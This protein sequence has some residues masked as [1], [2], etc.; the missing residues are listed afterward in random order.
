M[1]RLAAEMH[2]RAVKVEKLNRIG[3]KTGKCLKKAADVLNRRLAY[4]EFSAL[5]HLKG[6]IKRITHHLQLSD[7][8]IKWG[9]FEGFMEVVF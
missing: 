9:Y 8:I 3:W 4:Y 7:G 5:R 6:N 1:N 2:V